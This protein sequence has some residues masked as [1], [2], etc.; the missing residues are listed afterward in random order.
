MI[1]SFFRGVYEDG[2]SVGT[3]VGISVSISV[4]I[5]V[6]KGGTSVDQDEDIPSYDE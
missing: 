2:T 4:S 3:N 5:S 1:R 6:D